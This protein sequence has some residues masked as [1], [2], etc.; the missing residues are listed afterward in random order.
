MPLKDFITEVMNILK[1]SPEAAEISVERVKP[2]RQAEASGNYDAFHKT[3]TSGQ[4]PHIPPYRELF[5]GRP[6][7]SHPEKYT[8]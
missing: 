3:S 5:P 7:R 8:V 2:L 6:D 4:D 1:N